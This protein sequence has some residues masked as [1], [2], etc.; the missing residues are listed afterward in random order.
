M[1]R[2]TEMKNGGVIIET[3]APIDQI[4]EKSG[5]LNSFVYLTPAEAEKLAFELWALQMDRGLRSIIN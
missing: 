1:I 3:T 4:E 2:I 5:A